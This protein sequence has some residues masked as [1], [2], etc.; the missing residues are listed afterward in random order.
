[1]L[2]RVRVNEKGAVPVLVLIAALG[3]IG[4]LAV[5]SSAPLKNK[6][7]DQLF[8]KPASHAVSGPT[9]GPITPSPSPT[10]SPSATPAPTP[11]PDITPPSVN[12]TSPVNGSTVR[13]NSNVTITATASDIG[14]VAKVEF[15]AAGSLVCTDTTSPYSCS[16]RV[17]K[18]PRVTYSVQAKA[19]DSSNNSAQH[20][21]SVTSK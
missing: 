12:I 16:W 15:Y 6:V 5:S 20:S 9:S 17:P 13:K 3:L 7:L 8:P 4:F 14:G 11:A 18:A 19:Y 2:N 21:I 1:M 10:A